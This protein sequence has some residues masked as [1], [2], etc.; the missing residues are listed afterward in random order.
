MQY[1]YVLRSSDKKH[2]YVG[3]T[4]DIQKRLLEHNGRDVTSTKSY[5]PWEVFY[6][7]AFSC[8][9]KAFAREKALK[10]HAK[11]LIMLKKRI[12]L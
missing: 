1:V 3:C 10:H 5:A 12:G 2:I 9:K 8:P 4:K 11:S 6:Y 7:E